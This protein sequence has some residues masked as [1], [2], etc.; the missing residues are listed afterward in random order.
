MKSCLFD[1]DVA[2]ASL[3]LSLTYNLQCL[4]VCL[5]VCLF[6]LF[7]FIFIEPF[8]CR[9][10][11]FSFILSQSLTSYWYSCSS[12]TELQTEDSSHRLIATVIKQ[13]SNLFVDLSGVQVWDTLVTRLNQHQVVLSPLN[14]LGMAL[15]GLHWS[16][17][18]PF[19][20]LL[21]TLVINR[22]GKIKDVHAHKL[23][24]LRDCLQYLG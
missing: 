2:N 23:S 21:L 20:D 22:R 7:I 9:W 10:A 8:L 5:P 4:F 3:I 13:F 24:F 1:L 18:E 14:V 11:Y 16:Q 6:V 15:V 17:I 12:K 19:V